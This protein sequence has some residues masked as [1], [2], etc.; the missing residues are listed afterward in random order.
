ML[1]RIEWKA[2][3]LGQG[4]AMLTLSSTWVKVEV[5]VVGPSVICRC[6]ENNGSPTS[7]A[8]FDSVTKMKAYS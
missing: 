4:S 1:S 5:S 3:P 6:R 8:K 7:I 2:R